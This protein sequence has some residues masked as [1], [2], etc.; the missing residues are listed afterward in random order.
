MIDINKYLES[1]TIE[2]YYLGILNDD[3]INQLMELRDQH[4]AVKA[5]MEEVAKAN[6]MF[7]ETIQEAPPANTL[8]AIK[9]IIKDDESWEKAELDSETKRLPRYINISKHSST[10]KIQ[11]VVRELKPAASYDNIYPK[12][13][14]ADE[15][16]SMVLVWV[17]DLVPLEKHPHLDESFLVLEGTADCY[18]DD[19]VFH[20]V[21]GDFMR[22]PPKSKHKVIVTSKTPAKAIKCAIAI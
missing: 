20:M 22:I 1:G 8:S 11:A 15:T 5:Y 6:A 2:E 18:I 9:S 10:E 16:R 7:F 3:Q 19:E 17:K 14:Y 21:P 4:P 13:L 12:L